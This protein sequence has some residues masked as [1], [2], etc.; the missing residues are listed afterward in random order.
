MP[1]V[2]PLVG[3]QDELQRIVEALLDRSASAVVLAGVAGVGKTRLLVEALDRLSAKGLV[4]RLAVATRS[5]SAI[6]FGAIAHLLPA[7]LAT[8]GSRSNLLRLAGESILEEAGAGSLVLGI[9]DAHLLDD[10]SAALVHHLALQGNAEVVTAVRSGEQAPDPI[11]ALWKDQVAERV[12]IPALSRA[13]VEELTRL[14][15]GSQVDRATVHL[16]WSTTRGNP[17]FL[18]ELILGGLQAGRLQQ[19]DGVWIWRGP[20]AMSARLKEVLDLRLRDLASG[21]RGALAI[22]AIAGSIELSILERLAGSDSVEA[23]QHLGLLEAADDGGR[24]VEARV[25]HPLYGE[26]ARKATPELGIR[27][28]Q[29]ALADAVQSTGARRREDLPR[30]ATWRLEGGDLGH[31]DQMAAAARRALSVFDAELAERLARAAV[32][33]GGGFPAAIVA[34]EAVMAQGR[35]LEAEAMLKELSSTAATDI[36]RTQAVVAR[37]SNLFWHLGQADAVRRAIEEGL[38][39]VRD[40]ALR[41]AVETSLVPSL[42]FGGRTEEALAIALEVLERGSADVRVLLEAATAAS[43]GLAVA[44]RTPDAEAVIDRWHPEA[45][46]VAEILPFAHFWLRG[47]RYLVH[48]WAGEVRR[49]VQEGEELYEHVLALHTGP[50]RAP[51][52]FMIGSLTFLTGRIRSASAWLRE[53]IPLL[54][55]VDLL[56]H[57]SACLGQLA[58]CSALLGDAATAERA[59]AEA[60]E[61]RVESFKMDE[62]FIGLGQAWTAV[63]RGETSRGLDL[64]LSTAERVGAM[65][66]F[67]FE[68]EALHDAT[69]L[70]GAGRAATRLNELGASK[71][72]E[73][74]AAFAAHAGALV[75]ADAQGLL[76]VSA[77]FEQMGMLL[78]AAEASAEAAAIFAAAGRK[79]SALA[80]TERARALAAM[81][82][83]ARTPT[84]AELETPLPIT[85]REREIATMAA[86]GLSNKEIARRLVVSVRT[87]DNHL[88]A[89]YEKLGIAGREELK[90][91][92][93]PMG[94]QV[95]P[96]RHQ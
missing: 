55:E 76:S 85:P 17:L 7:S 23:L 72:S 81:C 75:V 73:L 38:R 58:R 62:V 42:L 47:N 44:G 14:V 84:L 29:L 48:A 11:V 15:L 66:Q 79:G 4:T 33:G 37:G 53:A 89:V 61:C 74:V 32:D 2:W 27:H 78:Y 95:L 25:S 21:E 13:E 80:A 12:E 43:F 35:F 51:H 88:H 6:P 31:A 92:L 36:E 10:T 45:E 87:V 3:R 93:E 28:I 82:E 34:A 22:A 26:A 83:G 71:D 69:S 46:A 57:R 59:L 20:F 90:P 40:P 65:G 24:R 18:R 41:D 60:E 1:P 30:V 70:G 16:L 9:D 50:E 77:R 8:P 63:A 56:R 52:A 67:V 54:R 94:A 91:I 64:A 96:S 86:A 19:L 5:A 49:A 68:A 39:G